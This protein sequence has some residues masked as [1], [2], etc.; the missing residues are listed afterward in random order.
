MDYLDVT[1]ISQATCFITY[2]CFSTQRTPQH[3]A[4]AA[5]L[6]VM[7]QLYVSSDRVQPTNLLDLPT[8]E[9]IIGNW[10]MYN[11]LTSEVCLKEQA[12][13]DLDDTNRS[14]TTSRKL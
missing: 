13:Q 14:Q 2:N 4:Q 5:V 12:T 7:E 6:T 11:R 9:A 1:A 10:P 3:L 8:G